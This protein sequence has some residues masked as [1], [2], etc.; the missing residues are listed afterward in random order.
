MLRTALSLAARGMHVFP[1]RPRDKRPAVARGVLEAT[2]D[3]DVIR[4]WW[5]Q[6][7]E[8]NVAVATG[9]RSGIFVL[10]LDNEN[11]ESELRKIEAQHGSQQATVEVIT[12]RG[13]DIYF[14]MPNAVVRNSAGKIAPGID[15]RGDGGYV[16]AP[17]SIHPSG[18]RY[19]WSVDSATIFAQPP[20]WLLAKIIASSGDDKKLTVQRADWCKLLVEGVFEGQRDNEI[21]RF[22]GY[23][24]RH[25]IDPYVTLEVLQLVNVACCRPPLPREDIK[26]IVASIA[27][28]EINRRYGY[29]R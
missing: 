10:D 16:L 14:R 18:R 4:N 12:A 2:T 27:G 23:F 24:L 15:V 6:E 25:R 19:A 22:C 20:E 17:P 9:R 1:C 13:R 28:K 5:R 3:L 11:A 7:P 26:R 29:V 21:T 8:F